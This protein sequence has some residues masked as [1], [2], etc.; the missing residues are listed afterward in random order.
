[1]LPSDSEGRRKLRTIHILRLHYD[2][3]HSFVHNTQS[4]PSV[5]SVGIC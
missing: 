5:T 2:S 4:A 1:M 3:S